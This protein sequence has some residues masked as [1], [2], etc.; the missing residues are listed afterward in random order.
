MSGMAPRAPAKAVPPQAIAP[1]LERSGDNGADQRAAVQTWKGRAIEEHVHSKSLD[2][3]YRQWLFHKATRSP[4]LRDMYL[5]PQPFEQTLLSLKQGADYLVVSQSDS[6]IAHLG[7]DLR[8]TLSSERK[9]ATSNSLKEIFDECIAENQPIYARYIS[10]LSNRDAYWETMILPLTADGTGRPTFTLCYMN[11]LNEKV[12]M[13][14]ILYDRSPVGM[15]A[16]VPI[17][18]GQNRTDDARILTM[19]TRARELLHFAEDKG[20]PHTVGELIRYISTDL[21]WTPTGSSSIE[22]GTSILYQDAAGDRI[23]VTIELI[24][25]FILITVAPAAVEKGPGWNRFARL[26]G[27][28]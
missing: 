23:S 2:R 1:P 25:H 14:R 9:F 18:D 12:D 11:A 4:R 7:Y 20:Q 28:S 5:D 15:V 17:K 6:H 21:R 22:Q 3:A 8:G 26:V 24:N 27:L 10:S 19:N 16:A 13:L